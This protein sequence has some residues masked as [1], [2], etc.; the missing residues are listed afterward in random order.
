ME[1]NDNAIRNYNRNM[2]LQAYHGALNHQQAK[3]L[4]EYVNNSLPP[5]TLRED[6]PNLKLLLLEDLP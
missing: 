2:Q 6:K 3:C 1:G 5:A 4:G